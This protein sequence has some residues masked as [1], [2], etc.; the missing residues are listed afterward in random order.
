MFN[1]KPLE[2][3]EIFSPAHMTNVYRIITHQVGG[4]WVGVRGRLWP[5]LVMQAYE[6]EMEKVRQYTFVDFEVCLLS[7][8]KAMES[9]CTE[10]C[11]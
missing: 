10:H 3:V 9:I 7:L 1:K 2:F 11:N 5:K 8:E 4:K 6:C